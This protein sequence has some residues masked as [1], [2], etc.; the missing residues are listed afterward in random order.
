MLETG[1]DR[2]GIH[3][4]T[5]L[6]TRTDRDGIQGCHSFIQLVQTKQK[7]QDRALKRNKFIKHSEIKIES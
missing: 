3:G 6:E 2:D 7:S 1:T 4:Y 5:V